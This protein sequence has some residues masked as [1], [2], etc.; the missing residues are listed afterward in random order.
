[1]V[2][3]LHDRD[4]PSSTINFT[5]NGVSHTAGSV[6]PK[7]TLNTY[8]REYGLTGT[9]RS[10]GEGGC[11]ACTVMAVAPTSSGLPKAINSCYRPLVSCDGWHFTTIEG[12][13]QD[14]VTAS[15]LPH[16]GMK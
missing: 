7:L 16:N 10:C 13:Q 6:D 12:A 5:L 14:E 2:D 3:D 4:S 15:Y 8:I 11:G 1:M 9:K